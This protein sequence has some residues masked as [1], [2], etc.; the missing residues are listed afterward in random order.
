MSDTNPLKRGL[1]SI[2]IITPSFNQG[3]FIEQTIQSVLDQRYPNLE[4]IVVDGGSR[5]ETIDILKRYDGR[6]R[7]IS[8]KDTGQSDAINKGFRMAKGEILAW[9]NSDDIYLPGALEKVGRYFAEQPGVMM[10]YG[11]GYMLDERGNVKCRFPFT[12]PKF[13]L[14]KLIY[15]GDYVLQQSTFFRRSVFDAIEMLDESLHYT[16]DWDLFIRIGK[17]FRVDYI[18]EYLGAIR[19]H[20]E[21]KTSVGGVGRF[22]EIKSII[23]KHGVMRYPLSYFNYMWDAYGKKLPGTVDSK[24]GAPRFRQRMLG[25]GIEVVAKI[26][27][28]YQKRL[29]QGHYADGWVGKKAMVV[30]P[31]ATPREAK[32][33]L[34]IHGEAEGANTPFRITIAVNRK[35]K[36]SFRVVK[37][38]PFEITCDLPSSVCNDDSFH[39]EMRSSRASVPSRIGA[40][41]DGRALAFLL[42]RIS[43]ES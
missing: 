5:D 13:D 36:R 18:P 17:R 23:R 8:E 7:W 25:V 28:I 38:G 32:S 26:F 1:P 16:M 4:Y 31:N 22:E 11:E 34:L 30:L 41:A 42:R 10:V 20:G 6:L 21:A 35:T 43:V 3:R 29:Q 15:F 40:S 2:T 39:V 37:P 12:E 27:A 24:N 9:L 33:H 14:W 19:E